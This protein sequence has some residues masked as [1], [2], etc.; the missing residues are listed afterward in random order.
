VGRRWLAVLTVARLCAQPSE[1]EVAERWYQKTALEDLL[2]VGW[3][4]IH[5]D[6]LY[7][8]LE[9]LLEQ[10]EVLMAQLM[11][12]CESWFGVRCE[13]LVYDLTTVEEIVTVMERKYGKAERIWVLDRG[14]VSEENIEFLQQRPAYYAVGTPESELKQ[15]EH[16]LLDRLGGHQVREDVEVK[17]VGY[18]DGQGAEQYVL[19]RSRA[20]KEEEKAMLA[21]QEQRLLEKLLEQDR[22][23]QR[24]AQPPGAAGRRLGR[25]LGRYPAAAAVIEVEILKGKQKRGCG[26]AIACRR[27]RGQWAQGA[28][29]AY[30]SRIHCNEKDPTKVWERTGKLRPAAGE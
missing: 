7:R 5:E 12:R 20:R 14:M 23:L 27:D 24:K 10:K 15:F 26:L 29:G 30:L 11:R 13:F 19:C 16:Q 8:G 28:Q 9:A 22:S 17:R 25:W 21:R 6:R 4:K 2:G 18:P 1:Q 3:E